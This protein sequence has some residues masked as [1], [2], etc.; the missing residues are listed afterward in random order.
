MFV[1]VLFEKNTE[2]CVRERHFRWWARDREV[3]REPAS[4]CRAFLLCPMAHARRHGVMRARHSSANSEV[5]SCTASL[6]GAHV[7]CWCLAPCYLSPTPHAPP[8]SPPAVGQNPPLCFGFARD[9]SPWSAQKYHPLPCACGLGI[10]PP[11]GSQPPRPPGAAAG[12]AGISMPGGTACVGE[13]LS[14]IFF[15]FFLVVLVL[16]NLS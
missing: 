10:S 8:A 13:I 2:V 1:F 3:A 5:V 6:L 4:G 12:L 9:T 11:H 15:L 16:C 14:G 7:Q